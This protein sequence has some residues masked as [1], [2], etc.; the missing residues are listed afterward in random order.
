[1]RLRRTGATVL[2]AFAVL[3]GIAGPAAAD[4]MII[5]KVDTTNFP[6]VKLSV[7]INGKSID[8]T[9]FVLRENRQL[10]TGVV[11]SPLSKTTQPV[12]VVLV[13][14]I[15]GSMRTGGKIEQAK[16]AAK[17]FVANRAANTLIALV[18]FSNEVKVVS[19]FTQDNAG[20]TAAIDALVPTGETALWDGVRRGLALFDAKPELQRNMVILSDGA[21]TVSENTADGARSGALT[22]KTA[23][24]AVGIKGGD[25]ESGPL[26]AMAKATGGQYFDTADPAALGSLYA[27]VQRSIQENQYEITYTSAAKTPTIDVT[28][29]AGDA[30]VARATSISTGGT[31]AEGSQ[32]QPIVVF[33]GGGPSLMQE[34]WFKWIILLMVILAA[35]GAMVAIVPLLTGGQSGLQTALQPYATRP[36]AL[37][38]DDLDDDG[39]PGMNLAETAFIQR[40]VA[41]TGRFAERRGLMDIVERKLEVSDL[42]VRAAEGIFFWLVGAVVVGALGLALN[43]PLFGLIALFFGLAT[44]A[45]ILNFM[46]TRRRKKFTS[47]LPDSLQL[48]A[49]SLRAG[50]S[51]MQGVEAVSQESPDPIGK[52]LRRV[53]V[54]A[55]LGRPLEEALEDT[56]NRLESKDFEWAVMAIRIQREVGGNLAELLDTVGETMLERER[57]RREVAALTAEGKISAIVLGILPIGI[58]FALWVIN[59]EYIQIL[60]DDSF[61][62]TLMIGAT[63]LALVGFYW[64]K[65]VIEIEI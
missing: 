40:A 51:L 41:A 53:V 29:A 35:V 30:L 13:V 55:R 62:K 46:T 57:L 20:L 54:E 3:V 45:A 52:E 25:F 17:Q 61:G 38:D 2:I 43:G 4:N 48:L 22:N 6:E 39:P 65:K 18:V 8:P 31:V 64:M 1:M 47:Q 28:V 27:D 44:P 19:D 63:L 24:F 21:D 36:G 59:R 7:L 56:A 5:R 15:S 32:A 9:S 10:V 42:P 50:Y 12:G 49:G 23:V 11:V 34:S 33:E 26:Q 60:F 37:D 14:D 16:A 58:G